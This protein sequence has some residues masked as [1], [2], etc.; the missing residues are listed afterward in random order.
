[1]KKT[2]KKIAGI[3]KEYMKVAEL[4]EVR[5]GKLTMKNLKLI[6]EDV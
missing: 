2:A 3:N 4:L 1:M 6:G 5:E